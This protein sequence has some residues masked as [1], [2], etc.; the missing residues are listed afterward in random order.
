MAFPKQDRDTNFHFKYWVAGYTATPWY[1]MI[2]NWQ[3]EG[4][5]SD[6]VYAITIAVA[7][8]VGVIL[9][10]CI[11]CCLNKCCASEDQEALDQLSDEQ[12][13]QYEMDGTEQARETE[14][15]DKTEIVNKSKQM[16]IK[17]LKHQLTQLEFVEKS[18]NNELG[19]NT[20]R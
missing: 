14:L 7:A 3:F 6:M 10:C 1:D 15:E 16:R 12:A 5:D 19:D 2:L 18:L 4:K 8:F 17:E 11:F 20:E 9:L 13:W